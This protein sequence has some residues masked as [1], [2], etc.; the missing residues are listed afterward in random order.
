[1]GVLADVLKEIP[2]NSVLRERLALVE[3][4]FA[5]LETENDRLRDEVATLKGTVES[6]RRLVPSRDFV[7]THGVLFKRKADGSLDRIVYCPKCQHA[8]NSL[9]DFLPF[10]CLGC[11]F[12]SP[13]IRRELARV[14]DEAAAE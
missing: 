12:T 3:A 8:M 1:M 10:D 13:F 4:K 11:R 6:L 7:E 5:A 2:T 9:E 14:L